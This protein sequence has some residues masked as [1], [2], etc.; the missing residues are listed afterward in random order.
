MSPRLAFAI[1][2]AFRAGRSTLELFDTGVAVEMK[3]DSTPVTQADKNAEEI[4]RRAVEARY[5][6][7]SVLG[8]EQ[9]LTGSGDDRWIVDPIDGTKAFIAGVPLYATL[10]AYEVD[11]R[12]ILGVCYLPAIDV[13]VYAEEAGGAWWNGRPI[14][15]RDTGDLAAEALACGGHSNMI[16]MD[17]WRSF[18]TL[19]GKALTTRTWQDAYGHALVAS[20]RIAAMIDPTVSR[21][22]ISAMIPIVREAGGLCTDFDG[23]DPLAREELEMISCAPGVHAE[24]IEAFRR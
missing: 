10:L 13:M 16:K 2:A 9:G 19:I 7:D 3:G 1:D 4:I 24:V 11:R 20:G 5:P 21:W 17:R 15:V 8:E 12:P 18:E 23:G 14:R 22:D 6:G